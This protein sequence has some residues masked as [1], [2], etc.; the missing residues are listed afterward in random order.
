MP[1]N[2]RS[3]VQE[4]A[5]QTST[6]RK[7]SRIVRL[8]VI[9][10]LI[11]LGLSGVGAWI[12]LKEKSAGATQN[13]T[14]SNETNGSA[15]VES[16]SPAPTP[17]GTVN[18]NLQTS[19]PPKKAATRATPVATTSGKW[20]IILGS[21]PKAESNKANE[22]LNF[23]RGRGYDARIVDSDDYPN[24]KGGLW[25]VVMGP[26]A[27]NE[28]EGIKNKMRSIVPDAYAKSGW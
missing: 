1:S 27:R 26:F 7:T 6:S 8:A 23:I 22:R 16:S 4:E 5:A 20:F 9:A 3:T 11:L 13:T 28:A 17:S 24:L 10:S 12:L 21:Y 15:S 25:V 14:S 18:N 2:P 19:E